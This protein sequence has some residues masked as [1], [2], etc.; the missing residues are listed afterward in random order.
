MAQSNISRYGDNH[1]MLFSFHSYSAQESLSERKSLVEE[2]N[3]FGFS[4]CFSLQPTFH[5]ENLCESE[6]EK[7]CSC[8]WTNSDI[9]YQAF[10]RKN[11]TGFS[12]KVEAQQESDAFHLQ[13]H[14]HTHTH[15]IRACHILVCPESD[16]IYFG[17]FLQCEK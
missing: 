11:T 7:N 13:I 9:I 17:Y 15:V 12:F 5:K 6:R 4:I 14:S 16:Q 3:L 2:N 1:I 10:Y 8:R